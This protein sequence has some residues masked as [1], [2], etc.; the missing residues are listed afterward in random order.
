MVLDHLAREWLTQLLRHGL[1]RRDCLTY[2][3]LDI[4]RVVPTALRWRPSR[5]LRTAL[6]FR[7]A[8]ATRPQVL[9]DRMLLRLDGWFFNLGFLYL[10]IELIVRLVVVLIPQVAAPVAS[11]VCY[12]LLLVV[13]HD[14][15]VVHLFVLYNIFLV[16][17]VQGCDVGQARIQSQLLIIN[18]ALA[19]AAIQ[20]AI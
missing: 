19:L 14:H 12:V 17:V 1:V 3:L 18:M 15:D 13:F 6:P 16:V 10:H 8:D 9:P 20:F 2:M 5:L 11:A 7:R 4:L